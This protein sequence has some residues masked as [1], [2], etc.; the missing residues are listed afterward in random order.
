MA[1]P[2]DAGA[3]NVFRRL[4]KGLGACT[5][6]EKQGVFGTSPKP[7]PPVQNE[8]ATPGEDRSGGEIEMKGVENLQAE[9]YSPHWPNASAKLPNKAALAR[10]WPALKINRLTWRWCDDASGAKGADLGSLLAFLGEGA[11]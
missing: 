2:R 9:G 1:L 4:T 6:L 8:T 11:R 3:A 7:A 5:P 10:K